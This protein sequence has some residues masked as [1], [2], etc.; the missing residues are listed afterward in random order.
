MTRLLL[1]HALQVLG[2]PARQL[3]D[4][5]VQ[6]LHACQTGCLLVDT[7]QVWIASLD[8]CAPGRHSG[9]FHP[10]AVSCPQVLSTG[11]RGRGPPG[12]H[13]ARTK[14]DCSALAPRF[15]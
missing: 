11:M 5:A 8:C 13:I 14:P 4:D 7:G 3:H 6:L 9:I 1:A 12:K 15:S 10:C 2:T